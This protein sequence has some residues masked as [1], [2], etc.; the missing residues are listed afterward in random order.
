MSLKLDSNLDTVSWRRIGI[1]TSCLFCAAVSFNEILL[2]TANHQPSLVSDADL[3][4]DLYGGIGK[5]GREDVV[6]LGASRMQTGMDLETFYYRFPGKQ[7]LLLAQ[8]GKGSSYPVFKD[9]VEKTNYRG[10]AI[11]DETEGTLSDPNNDQQPFID[12]C[13][14]KFSIDR[15]L[16]RRLSTGLQNHLVFLNPQSSSLRLWGN[17]AV[18]RKL[19]VPFFTKTLPDRQQLTDYARADLKSLQELHASRL[20]GAED[21]STQPPIP[22]DRWVAK[23]QNWQQLVAKFQQRGGRVV[24]LRMPVSQDRWQFEQKIYPPALYWQP[25]M[26]QLDVRSIHFADYADLSN[27]KLPDTSH[28]DMRD[29]A[30]F[31][32]RLLGHIQTKLP[33]LKSVTAK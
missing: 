1:L 22:F 33:E 29:K 28:L 8:S 7:A 3:F 26:K 27:F 6:F 4:C 15:Q 14:T 2:R 30:V 23:T 19:P 13:H 12:H 16:N 24:F 18:E 31:T 21:S 32:E 10:I 11:I 25:W 20:K 9:I 17:L 5:L